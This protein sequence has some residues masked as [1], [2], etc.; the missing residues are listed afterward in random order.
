[1]LS[2]YDHRS[3]QTANLPPGPV[4]VHVHGGAERALITADLLR[5]VAGRGRLHPV[6]TRAADVAPAH[7]G[8]TE[9]SVPEFEIADAAPDG[10]LLVG[11]AAGPGRSLI[12]P[13]EEGDWAALVKDGEIDVVCVRLAMLR[14]RY[15]DPIDVAALAA[16]ARDDLKRWRGLVAGWAEGPGRPLARAYASEAET[17]LADDLDGPAALAVLDRLASDTAVA[18]GAK[19]ETFIHLDLLLGLDLVA[20]IGRT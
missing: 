17:A 4:R 1:M 19:L 9:L 2:L 10:A 8:F 7:C 11:P 18:P 12:I 15:R 13:P 3:G 6:V 5:R 20:D 16:A 14:A